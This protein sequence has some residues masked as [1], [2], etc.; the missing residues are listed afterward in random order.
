MRGDITASQEL[1]FSVLRYKK[2]WRRK[3]ASFWRVSI[4]SPWSR[5]LLPARF[6][7]KCIRDATWRAFLRSTPWR[8]TTWRAFF[9]ACWLASITGSQILTYHCTLRGAPI[10]TCRVKYYHWSFNIVPSFASAAAPGREVSA[11]SVL[12]EICCGIPSRGASGAELFLHRR[13]HR[14]ATLSKQLSVPPLRF[15]QNRPKRAFVEAEP[16]LDPRSPQLCSTSRH[17]ISCA[18]YPHLA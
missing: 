6:V 5:L 2:R 13:G 11:N 3:L 10:G 16:L 7:P 14:V 8:S 12:P 1:V 17:A 18:E 9:T 15:P 4:L